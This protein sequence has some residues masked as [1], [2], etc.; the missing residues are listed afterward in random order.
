MLTCPAT[1]LSISTGI[2][3]DIYS[4]LRLPSDVLSHTQC[5][6]CGLK[7]AWL[8]RDVWLVGEPDRQASQF[9]GTISK[10]GNG[11]LELVMSSEAE[12]YREYARE[13]AR[14]AQR[15]DVPD[16][17]AKLLDLASM[18]MEAAMYEEEKRGSGGR[19]T[20]KRVLDS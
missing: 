6:I 3:T 19:E 10:L 15:A 12:K 2:E 14:Q 20:T 8:K 1:G 13:C 16:L 11:G 18:W 4:F 17:R 5:P 9:A 7:H